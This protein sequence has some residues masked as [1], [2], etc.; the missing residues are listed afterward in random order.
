M[1]GRKHDLSGHF[2]GNGGPLEGLKGL[3]SC[4]WSDDAFRVIMY[5]K[6]TI[7]CGNINRRLPGMASQ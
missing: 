1:E 4:F 7:F 5:R 3:V 6:A 2:A